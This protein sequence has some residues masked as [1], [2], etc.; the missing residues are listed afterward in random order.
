MSPHPSSSVR[1]NPLGNSALT[2]RPQKVPSGEKIAYGLGDTATNLVW[3]TLMVFLPI[4]YTDVFGLSAAAVGTLLLICRYW[5]G[6]TDFI[7]GLIAD[8][9]STR[10][11]KFRPWILWTA[12][13]FGIFTVLNF[14]AM[15]LSATGKLIYAYATYSALII[16]FTANNIPYSALTG[17]M[18]ADP[19]ERTSIS[20]YRFF[21]A[22]LGGLLTQGLNIPLVA[23]FGRGDE[24]KGYTMTMT[25]FSIVSVLLFLLTFL[26]TKERVRPVVAESHSSWEDVKDLFRNRSW[27]IL[28]CIGLL[29]VTFTT[30]K[31]GV[32]MY[33]FKYFVGDTVLATAFMTSGLV[34]AMIGAAMTPWLSRTLGKR[35]LM[36]VSLAVGGVSSALL[37]L[38]GPSD[39][40]FMFG[41]SMLTEFSTG[42][43][44]ALFFAMLADASDFSEW[45]TGRRAT[46]LTFSAGTLSFKFGTGVAGALTGWVLTT[47]GYVANTAQTAETLLGIRILISVVPGVVALLGLGIFQWYTLDESHLERIGTDLAERRR[48]HS[49]EHGAEGMT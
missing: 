37:F 17:V 11:G 48:R 44:V 19:V 42:P 34:A 2:L 29:F 21:F 33:Y 23:A 46:G 4:F 14:T 36:S 25:L 39:F 43:I 16:A 24:V 3:R 13:P 41:L 35:R 45:Q 49:E 20:S 27:F 8:R 31:Q 28:F 12:V 26:G 40:M 47:V 5:D 7:M 15:D 30:L 9:T 10:W 32:T 38:A 6:I 18:T 1:G 22:F